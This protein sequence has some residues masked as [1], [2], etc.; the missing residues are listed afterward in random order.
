MNLSLFTRH[1][2][3]C[4]IFF[5]CLFLPISLSFGLGSLKVLGD[6]SWLDILGEGSLVILSAIWVLFVL[7]SRPPGK[8]TSALVIGLSLFLFSACLDLF[9]EWMR[10]DNRATYLNMFESIPAA[11]GMFIM[12]YALFQWHQEL[13]IVNQQLQRRELNLRQHDQVDF[14]TKLYGADYM[15]EQIN[16]QLKDS[17][18]PAFSIVM[19]DIDSFDSFN[20][21][22]GHDEGDRLLREVSELILMNLRSLDLVCRYA[23][24]RFILLL[25]NTDKVV[26]E[27]IA[28]QIRKAIVHL[29]YKPSRDNNAV[30]HSLTYVAEAASMEDKIAEAILSRVNRRLDLCKQS[31]SAMVI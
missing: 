25:P 19:L 31:I 9:D 11:F 27:E 28:E 20:R 22:Y 7:V 3:L 24:D 2:T 6:I 16:D 13:L 21:Q 5:G 1:S 14:I 26:A 8:V 30:Y 23:G 17:G 10:Y 29:A 12:S 15:R 4:S 18:N